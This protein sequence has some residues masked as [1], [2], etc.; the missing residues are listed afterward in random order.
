MM[1]SMTSENVFDQQITLNCSCFIEN[2]LLSKEFVPS[3]N[4]PV[5]MFGTL[6]VRICSL[7]QSHLSVVV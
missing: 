7:V 2:H 4:I 3:R 6:P 1:T 5:N